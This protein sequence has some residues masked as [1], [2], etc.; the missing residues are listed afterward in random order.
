MNKLRIN[1]VIIRRKTA[2][3]R[4]LST[5]ISAIYNQKTVPLEAQRVTSNR[6]K[7]RSTVRAYFYTNAIPAIMNKMKLAI[8]PK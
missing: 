8:C 3:P 5:V 1:R 4:P 6:N 7:Q 2:I